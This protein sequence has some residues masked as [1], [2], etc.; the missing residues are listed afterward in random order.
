MRSWICSWRFYGDCI[1]SKSLS[2]NEHRLGSGAV[3]YHPEAA[4]ATAV[5]TLTAA[6]IRATSHV[7]TGPPGKAIIDEA[8][9]ISADLIIMGHRHLSMLGR[10]ANPSIAFD[11]LERSD[12]PVLLDTGR[13][14]I[15]GPTP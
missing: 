13:A 1:D 14:H 2:S 11:V 15:P 4:L 9:L 8:R 5:A 10:F 6:G 3:R 7:A 12:C